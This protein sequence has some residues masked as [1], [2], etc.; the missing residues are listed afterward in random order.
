M[1]IRVAIRHHTSYTYD[2]EVKLS[3]QVIRLRPA[4]HARNPIHGYSLKISPAEHF[5][6]WQQDPFGNYQ[7]RV[8]FPEKTREL[9]I[10]VEVITDMVTVNPFDFFLEDYAENFPFTYEDQLRA[11]LAPYLKISEE[12]PLLKDFVAGARVAAL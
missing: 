5:I 9:S 8:V 11:E 6:N 2:R 12:G 3:P 1:P 7:A 4:P 10:D